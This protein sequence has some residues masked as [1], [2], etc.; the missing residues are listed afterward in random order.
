MRSVSPSAFP[1][2]AGP[3]VMGGEGEGKEGVNGEWRWAVKNGLLH[4]GIYLRVL[5][6]PGFADAIGFV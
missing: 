2:P 5:R 3:F 4:N 1:I 6:V